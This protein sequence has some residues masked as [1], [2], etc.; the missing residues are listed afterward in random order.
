MMT[1]EPQ[2]GQASASLDDAD[3]T[4]RGACTGAITAPRVADGLGD[5]VAWLPSPSASPAPST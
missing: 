5:T 4:P 2:P 1:V 3:L